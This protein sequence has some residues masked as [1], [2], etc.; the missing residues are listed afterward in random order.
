MSAKTGSS[1]ENFWDE[2]VEEE[3]ECER[4]LQHQ[5][6]KM[7]ED[8][9]NIT[10]DEY[11]EEVDEDEGDD[12]ESDEDDVDD[13]EAA[14]ESENNADP[15]VAEESADSQEVTD[16]DPAADA[17]EDAEAAKPVKE[18]KMAKTRTKAGGKTKAEAIREIIERRQ[19]AKESL[20]PRDI[21]EELNENGFEVN[22]SQV[23]V[24]L[25]NMGVP[26]APK[27]RGKGTAKPAAATPTEEQKSR[28]ALKR[29]V[30]GATKPQAVA[31]TDGQLKETELMLDSAAEFVHTA[32]GYEKAVALL[33]MYHRIVS[34][35]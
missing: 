11:D 34:R 12:E 30:S 9:E 4:Y 15:V 8:E 19:K 13:S 5:K 17:E 31:G 22:A 3:A 14:E 25:R 6:V 18:K 27:G 33:N 24:T 10:E 35:N 28:M 2:G 23:S 29:G 7:I 21:I 16:D 26:P 20:R 1:A 32:G